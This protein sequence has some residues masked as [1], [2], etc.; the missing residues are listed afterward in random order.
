M[1]A[2]FRAYFFSVVSTLTH[3][4]LCVFEAQ[5]SVFCCMKKYCRAI[6]GQIRCCLKK[7]CLV[8]FF[9]FFFGKYHSAWSTDF[10]HIQK[11]IVKSVAL[12]WQAEQP[13][14]WR[15]IEWFDA[16]VIHVCEHVCVEK[17]GNQSRENSRQ[18][19]WIT[20]LLLPTSFCLPP[21]WFKLTAILYPLLYVL[22]GSLSDVA[23]GQTS[24]M[25]G[26]QVQKV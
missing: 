26:A 11:V 22:L 12:T 4:L 19:P 21:W 25:N 23:S 13:E 8:N 16:L 2:E 7:L 18:M 17:L 10:G 5:I 9:F 3:G 6:I 24:V 15:P 1:Q 14:S 20:W